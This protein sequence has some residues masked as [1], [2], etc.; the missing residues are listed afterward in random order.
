V[1]AILHII[2]IFSKETPL[3]ELTIGQFEEVLFKFG[4]NVSSQRKNPQ[5]NYLKTI[6][7]AAFI[8]KSPEA[9][10]QIVYNGKIKS[11]KRGNNLLFLESDL[12]EWLESGRKKTIVELSRDA[13]TLLIKRQND[14]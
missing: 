5:S 12:I 13:E 14:K 1:G 11:I 10:R 8:R 2:M 6:E 9:L 3:N 4:L 7:A